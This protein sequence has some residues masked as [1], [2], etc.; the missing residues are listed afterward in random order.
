MGRPNTKRESLYT[1]YREALT[2]WQAN[3]GTS[4]HTSQPEPEDYGLTTWE[5]KA[6]AKQLSI[7]L[8]VIEYDA[9]NAPF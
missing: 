7:E 5:G 6:L 8:K 1:I 3:K 2:K 9:D 4:F